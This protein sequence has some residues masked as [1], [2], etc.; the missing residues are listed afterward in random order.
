MNAFLTYLFWPNPGNATYDS[1]KAVALIVVCLLMM[2][3][4]FVISFW[5][6]KKASQ[7]MRKISKTWSGAAFW[8]GLVGLIL[9]VARAEQIQYV[10]MRFMWVLWLGFLLLYAYFQVKLYRNRYYE[11]IPSQPTIDPRSKYL[12]KKKR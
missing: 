5:R 7:P 9:V 4:A 11:V 1:P 8:F 3:L 12:P 10:S 6:K 2:V